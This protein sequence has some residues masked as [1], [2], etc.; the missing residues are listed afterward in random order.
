MFKRY[1]IAALKA[2]HAH[3][4]QCWMDA[5]DDYDWNCEEHIAATG[6]TDDEIYEYVTNAGQFRRFAQA[7]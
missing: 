5:C 6:K 4:D 3:F 1:A 2:Q 7:R